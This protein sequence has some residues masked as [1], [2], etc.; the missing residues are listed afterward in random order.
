[1]EPLWESIV[2]EKLLP[3]TTSYCGGFL[4]P[5]RYGNSIFNEVVFND[6]NVLGVMTIWLQGKKIHTDQFHRS[7]GSDVD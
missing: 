2:N 6:Q 7:A 3:K 1:M 4:V 5:S